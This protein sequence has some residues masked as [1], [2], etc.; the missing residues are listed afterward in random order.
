MPVTSSSVAAQAEA[1]AEVESG[2]AR[3]KGSVRRK[4]AP[5]RAERLPDMVEAN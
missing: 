5:A 2:A 1:L 3:A 4:R